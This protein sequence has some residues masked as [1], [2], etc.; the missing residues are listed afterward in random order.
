MSS[1]QHRE[2]MPTAATR[3]GS[4]RLGVVELLS[5]IALARDED[6]TFRA[7]DRVQ[8][9]PRGKGHRMPDGAMVRKVVA[10]DGRTFLYDPKE[11]VANHQNGEPI[12][13]DRDHKSELTNDTAADGGWI[14]AVSGDKD[15][16]WGHPEWSEEGEQLLR[17]KRYR[18]QSPG[19]QVDM[20]RSDIESRTYFITGFSSY[21]LTNRPAMEGQ[22]KLLAS[23]Q[24]PEEKRMNKAILEALGLNEA[25]SESAALEAIRAAK[26]ETAEL[27]SKLVAVETTAEK[28]REDLEIAT[29]KLATLEE[30]RKDD[31]I[32]SLLRDGKIS[33]A[34]EEKTREM[35]EA[36]GVDKA[37]AWFEDAPAVSPS[38][39]PATQPPKQ[40][41]RHPEPNSGT[42]EL[43]SA[44][45]EWC[46]RSGV[47]EE[48]LIAQLAA[49]EAATGIVVN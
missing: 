39:L 24:P 15:G 30:K 43:T 29:A 44:Q 1:D 7:P 48:V 41:Q 26:S 8:M 17:T 42:T 5:T 34:R 19:M 49:T 31:A 46:K 32:A 38:T 37:L 36:M 23:E 13:I 40:G 4:N 28:A 16:I 10:K 3:E 20:A 14:E 27:K 11:I 9:L 12:R 33:P 2:Y 6:G 45:R 47:K 35:F 25:A 21:A 18:K 22:L